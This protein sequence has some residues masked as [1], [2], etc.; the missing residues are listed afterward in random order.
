MFVTICVLGGRILTSKSYVAGTHSNCNFSFVKLIYFNLI[1]YVK[2]EVL[3]AI[4][5]KR[6]NF[7]DIKVCSPL[8]ADHSDSA[9]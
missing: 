2:F 3:T 7:W 4:V 5:M 1:F 6:D 9:V 8:K